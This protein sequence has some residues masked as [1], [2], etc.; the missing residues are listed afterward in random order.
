L[1]SDV[2]ARIHVVRECESHYHLVFWE[3]LDEALREKGVSSGRAL[4]YRLPKAEMPL[5]VVAMGSRTVDGLVGLDVTATLEQ[6][7]LTT[8]TDFRI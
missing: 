6:D 1:S 2:L 7:H 3:Y 5:V 8:V 4:H